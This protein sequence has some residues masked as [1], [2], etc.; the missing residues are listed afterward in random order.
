MATNRNFQS[1]LNEYLP[2]ELL[3]EELI[4]RDYFLM[5]VEKDNTWLGGN[6][7]I[8]FRGA[9]ASTVSLGAL[10]DAT[11]INQSKYVRGSLTFQPE[12]WASLIFNER[13]LL[14][15]GKISEQNFLKILPGEIDDLMNYFKMVISMSFTVGEVFAHGTSNGSNVG[16]ISVDRVERFELGMPLQIQTNA[17]GPTKAWVSVVNMNTNQ[18]TLTSDLA[19]T[20]PIDLSTYLL[21]DSPV[22]Y[23]D[24][25][26]TSANRFTS[27]RKSLLSAANG[28]TATLYG[29]SKLAYPYLQAINVSGALITSANILQK[30]FDGQTQVRNKGKG[31]PNKVIVSYN[32]LGAILKNIELSKGAFK[33]NDSPKANLFGW[34]EVE[35]YGVKGH[36]TVVAI[37]EM[38]NDVMFI[39]D[40][41]ALKIYTNGFFRK[42]KGPDGIEYFV[43]RNTSGFQYVVDLCL[44]GDIVLQRPSRCG[45]IFGV[46]DPLP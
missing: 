37:Q 10:T 39:L 27:I 3:K 24:G 40:M 42:R 44:F 11:L 25:A 4:K 2:N 35:I 13:D 33:Q 5:N 16:V 38:D 21:V 23:F 9:S 28:G 26:Q 43:I 45:I 14:E 36:I 17:V 46:P 18:V 20:T 29:Q 31:L 19:L 1:M 22:F 7:I 32:H 30:I 8:P 34:T 12:A 41:E 15:H 6:L